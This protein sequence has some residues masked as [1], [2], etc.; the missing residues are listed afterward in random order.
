MFDKLAPNGQLIFE[1]G[2][3]ADIDPSYYKYFNWWQYPDLLFFFGEDSVRELLRRAGFKKVHI[4]SWSILPELIFDRFVWKRGRRVVDPG[5]PAS[6]PTKA[7]KLSRKK[8]ALRVGAAYL[9]HFFRFTIGAFSSDKR[10]PR[11]MLIWAMK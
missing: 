8:K 2:N 1:T 3:A 10:V 5:V 7:S 9:R 6:A 11:T 4:V